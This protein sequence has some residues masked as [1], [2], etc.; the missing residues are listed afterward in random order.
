MATR[1]CFEDDG[2][3]LGVHGALVIA[4][5]DAQRPFSARAARRA[6]DEIARMRKTTHKRELVYAYVMGEQAAVPGAEA[7]QVL[8]ELP[9]HMDVAI[10][11]HEGSGFRASMMRA[12]AT[13]IAMASRGRVHPEIVATIPAAAARIHARLPALT[14]DEIVSAFERVRS[15][16]L[17]GF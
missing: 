6:V 7:R 13:G 3:A 12:V 10:G 4:V 17:D 16:A 15:V 14:E 8:S 1:I 2:T 9:E 5:I 11:V